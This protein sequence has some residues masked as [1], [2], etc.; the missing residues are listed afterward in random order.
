MKRR[1]GM[2][3]CCLAAALALFSGC[4]GGERSGK[5]GPFVYYINMDGTGLV[6][7]ETDCIG[8]DAEESVAAMLDELQKETDSID[9]RS[10][11]PKKLKVQ[12]W[13]LEGTSLTLDFNDVYGNMKSATEVLLRAAVVQSLLQIPGVDS[14]EFY[15]GGKPLTEEDGREVGLMQAGEFVQNTGSSLHSYQKGEFTLYFA[16]KKGDKLVREETSVRYNS[17]TSLEKLIVEQL[18]EGPQ[19]EGAYPTVPENTQILGVSVKDGICYVNLD[20]TFLTA[21]YNIDPRL[22]IYSLVNSIVG[23]GSAGKVQILVNGET[24]LSYQESVDISKPLSLNS[25]LIEEEE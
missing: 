24:D 14:V 17:N 1:I 3:L 6:K 11:F 4:S 13:K 10:A 25:D 12:E 8:E 19:T 21:S 5:T 9:Y 22:T 23:N 18:I 2:L 15:V 7:E 20:E 16:N